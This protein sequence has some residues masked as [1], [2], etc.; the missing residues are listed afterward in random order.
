MPLK[1]AE[2]N[3]VHYENPVPTSIGGLSLMF[4]IGPRFFLESAARSPKI[5]PGP[6]KTDPGAYLTGP[7]TGLR[8][9]WFGHSSLLVEVDGV[10]I[11]IDPVWDERA[12]PTSWVG[13]KRFFPPTLPIEALPRIDAVLISHDHFDHLRAR[14][15][16]G[17]LD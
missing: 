3:G 2:R 8:V 7:T 14:S 11:L 12:A 17:T 1:P 15:V 4:K 16:T 13:P 6:F 10:R 9:T 5:P